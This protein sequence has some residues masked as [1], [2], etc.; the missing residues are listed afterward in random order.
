MSVSKK[1]IVTAAISTVVLALV[2]VGAY[3]FTQSSDKTV[4]ASIEEAEDR[5]K[6]FIG[7]VN[8]AS[9]DY[10]QQ[11]DMYLKKSAKADADEV[12]E[13]VIGFNDYYTVDAITAWAENYG[14]TINHAYM[15]P[16]GE[17]GRMLLFVE[18][19]SFEASLESYKQEVEENGYCEDKQFAKDYQRFLDGEYGV[20][21][22]TVT[23]SAETLETINTE[24]DY[25]N[26]VDVMYNAEAETYAKKVGKPVSYIEL[27]SKPDGAL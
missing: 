3:A 9:E 21:A 22:L 23:A 4:S 13:A 27:P 8:R 1:T 5:V 7:D 17:T 14:I 19:N 26:Y 16:K 6:V 18:D 11:R 25:V 12:M 10:V 15:W 24:S 2:C 20:F